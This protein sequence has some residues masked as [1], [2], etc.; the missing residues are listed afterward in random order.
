[1]KRYSNSIENHV[2]DV[3]S[4]M[5]ALEPQHH[6][7]DVYEVIDR[8]NERLNSRA[9]VRNLT[10]E[11]DNGTP[12][13]IRKVKVNNT[14]ASPDGDS[15]LHLNK[16]RRRIMHNYL[17]RPQLKAGQ[18]LVT[19]PSNDRDQYCMEQQAIMRKGSMP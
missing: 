8:K 13:I 3:R 4:R 7:E 17:E 11:R 9:G 5:N 18:S 12:Y 19:L 2:R 1:M 10:L 15:G 16:S 6:T 14:L